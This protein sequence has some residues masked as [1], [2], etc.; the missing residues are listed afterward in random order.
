MTVPPIITAR[1][2]LYCQRHGITCAEIL[3]Q[4]KDG[5]VWSTSQQSALKIHNYTELYSRERDAY[6]RLRD[7][8]ITMIA[9]FRV[10]R[11]L[12]FDD[13]Y[14]AIDMTIVSPPYLLDFASATLD[15]APDLIEDEGHTLA[16]LVL[17]RFGDRAPEIFY[18]RQQLEERAGIFLIDIHP[19]NIKFGND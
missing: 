13:E 12:S 15:T 9:A 3:G 2:Q 10:P 19:H 11:L 14:L 8:K 16:D 5:C 7:C 4:G 1:M 6:I 17:E 18:V